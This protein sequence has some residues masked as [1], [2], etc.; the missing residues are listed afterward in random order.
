MHKRPACCG[1][2][3]GAAHHARL[4][5]ALAHIEV[6]CWPYPGAIALV[7]RFNNEVQMHVVSHWSYLGSVQDPT[8]AKALARQAAGFDADGYKILC[9]PILGGLTEIIPVW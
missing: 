4:I 3:D 6:Q 7:E 1:Q 9:R 2:E 8:E 5:S